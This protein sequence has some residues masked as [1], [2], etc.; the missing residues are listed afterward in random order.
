M[1]FLILAYDGTDSMAKERRLQ[2]RAE[3]IALGDKLVESRNMLF[4]AA[5]LENDQM[6]GSML[7]VDFPTREDVDNWLALEP[8]VIG[9]VWEKIEITSCQVGPSFE[10]VLK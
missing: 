2:M 8:Y 7:V 4:G 5:I 10:K 1:Q 3:H 6:I 9:N